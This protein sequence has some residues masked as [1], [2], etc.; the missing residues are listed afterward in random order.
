MIQEDSSTYH[1]RNGDWHK[2]ILGTF[3]TDCIG[4]Y[5][6]GREEGDQAEYDKAE[7]DRRLNPI[8][9]DEDF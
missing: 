5:G 2:V 6:T 8:V 7:E 9:Y 1:D 3:E 4:C